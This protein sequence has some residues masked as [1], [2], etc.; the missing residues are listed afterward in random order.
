VA[1]VSGPARKEAIE[2]RPMMGRLARFLAKRSDT[3]RPAGLRLAYSELAEYADENDLPQEE[4]CD[5]ALL[6]F[7]DTQ[8]ERIAA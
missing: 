3:P 2:L 5:R 4:F 8:S 7:L 6:I 1:P